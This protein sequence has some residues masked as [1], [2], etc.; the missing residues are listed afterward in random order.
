MAERDPQIGAGRNY[1]AYNEDFAAWLAAQA[2]MLRERRFDQLDV[3]HLAEEVDGV[4]NSEF[5]A[6]TSAIEL[7]VL[8]MMKWDYQV[9]RRGRSWRSKIHEQ[10]RQVAKLLKQNPS[11]KAR[12]N[13]AITDAYSGV[14]D[15]VEK[16]TTIP[17]ERLPEICPYSWD[18]I[19]TRLHDFDPDRPW[20][21]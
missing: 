17:A 20:P 18:D 3:E 16:Q 10:R 11:Y 14:P 2:L 1:P 12:I 5:R 9:E 13:E 8:H 4:G 6:F 19:M 21:N 15:E 7:I